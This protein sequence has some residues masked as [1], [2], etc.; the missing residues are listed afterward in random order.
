MGLFVF[1][2]FLFGCQSC[3][4]QGAKLG[5]DVE[6]KGDQSFFVDACEAGDATALSMKEATGENDCLQAWERLSRSTFLDLSYADVSDL[7]A[8]RGMQNLT[9]LSVYGKGISDLSPLSGLYY[10]EELSLMQNKI[11][12]ISPLERLV[13]LKLLH[14][15]GNQIEDIS[16]IANFNHLERLGLDDNYIQDFTPLVKLE[17]IQAMNT[18]DNPVDVNK[19]PVEGDMPKQLR[20]YCKRMRK[21]VSSLQDAIDPKQ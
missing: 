1:A 3:L 5:G 16:V 20:K 15:D 10:M 19:C 17:A 7:Q 2:L 4:H 21:H 14:L 12:D 8:V 13:Q 6:P 11:V 9:A 18:N